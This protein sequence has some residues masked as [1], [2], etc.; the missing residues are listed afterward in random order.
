MIEPLVDTVV[1]RAIREQAR[2]AALTCVKQTLFAMNIEEG[3]LLT[4]ETGGRQVFGGRRRSNGETDVLAVFVAE[5]PVRD[6]NLR[7]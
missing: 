5:T 1:N 3:L 2:E 4:G 6:E 7:R